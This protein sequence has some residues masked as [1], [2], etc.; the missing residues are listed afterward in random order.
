[1]MSDP[2]DEYLDDAFIAGFD[3]YWLGRMQPPDNIPSSEK[4]YW[5]RGYRAAYQADLDCYGDSDD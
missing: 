5:Y 3:G 2:R 4:E 1:M